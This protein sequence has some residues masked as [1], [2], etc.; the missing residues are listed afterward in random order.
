MR[1]KGMLTVNVQLYTKLP[2]TISLQPKT[3]FDGSG[4]LIIRRGS[5]GLDVQGTAPM[6]LQGTHNM[7]M[8]S[9][10][11]IT[12]LTKLNGDAMVQ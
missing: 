9:A 1:S 6:V 11:P 5:V 7:C 2:A 4:T 12:Q 10:S 8:T 3:S